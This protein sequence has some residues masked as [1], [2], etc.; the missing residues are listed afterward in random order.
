MRTLLLAMA[1][2][3]LPACGG[4]S[5]DSGG[6]SPPTPGAGQMARELYFQVYF[7]VRNAAGDPL[8]AATCAY[9]HGSAFGTYQPLGS[10][11]GTWA[12]VSGGPFNGRQYNFSWNFG[13]WNWN[14]PWTTVQSGST[15]VLGLRA[16]RPGS[17]TRTGSVSVANDTVL[18]NPGAYASGSTGISNVMVDVNQTTNPLDAKQMVYVHI[19]L[20]L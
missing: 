8:D 5:S 2:A 7:K 6:A 1:M 16:S 15:Y 17:T 3:L 10:T 20:V 14:A 4:G 11:T 13:T 9:A 18:D 12:T 19:T